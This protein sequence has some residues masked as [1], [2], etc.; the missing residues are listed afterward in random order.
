M[1]HCGSGH[2]VY[3]PCGCESHQPNVVIATTRLKRCREALHVPIEVRHIGLPLARD[4]PL[5]P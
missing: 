2:L 5:C 1:E 4:P 3:D